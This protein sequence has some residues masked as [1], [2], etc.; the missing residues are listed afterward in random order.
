MDAID[1][2]SIQRAK[3]SYVLVL[4][5]TESKRL[6][7]GKLGTFDFPAGYYL[8]F[9]SAL[10]GLQA[11]ISRHLRREKKLHWHIDFLTSVA[12]VA[13][14][15]WKADLRRLECS[16][17]KAAIEQEGVTVPVAGFGSSDCRCKAHLV[18]VE[19]WSHVMALR[20]TLTAN[21]EVFNILI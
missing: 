7:V 12:P 6:S 15:W 10:N 9:G 11:R 14:V 16:W 13:Q 2:D 21:S 1:I 3:G 19:S 8:Y 17:A 20:A 18:H 5:L 4:S